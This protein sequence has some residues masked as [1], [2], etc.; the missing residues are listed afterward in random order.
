M[1][2]TYDEV[3]ELGF[4]RTD[5]SDPIHFKKHGYDYFIVE[6][7]IGKDLYLDW[8]PQTKK[9]TL[10]RLNNWED[11]EIQSTREIVSS[12]DLIHVIAFFGISEGACETCGRRDYVV[13]NK[14]YHTINK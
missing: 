7:E 2:F 14:K 13:N 11:C 12:Q 5:Q 8:D 4:K 1:T 9:I 6:L 10:N 3:M